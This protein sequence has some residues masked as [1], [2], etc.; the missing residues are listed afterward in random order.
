MQR[1]SRP[2]ASR[3]PGWWWWT[4]TSCLCVEISG[5]R[6]FHA[7]IE[8]KS[9]IEIQSKLALC[10]SKLVK[11]ATNAVIIPLLKPIISTVQE[12]LA[13]TQLKHQ[14]HW[15]MR[16]I[17]DN[18]E[19]IKC[20]TAQEQRNNKSNKSVD[21]TVTHLW[22]NTNLQINRIKSPFNSFTIVPPW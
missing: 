10:S 13:G 18:K 7:E 17:T 19:R 12:I 21:L 1:R 9:I 14:H 16:R 3:T 15:E 22:M 20:S 2:A 6:K 5:R 8:K 4:T 11:K